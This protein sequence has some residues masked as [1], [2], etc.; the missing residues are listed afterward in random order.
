MIDA[1][2]SINN[3]KVIITRAQSAEDA[4][5]IHNINNTNNISILLQVL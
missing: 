2:L 3:N 1:Q 5:E 4:K